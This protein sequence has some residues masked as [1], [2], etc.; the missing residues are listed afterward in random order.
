M[1]PA[2]VAQVQGRIARPLRVVL[3]RDR[4]AEQCH[5]AVAGELRDRPLESMHALGEELEEAVH[6]PMPL[7]GIEL[8]GEI[9]RAL[10]VGEQHGHL[11]P[12]TFEGAA[13]AENLLGEMRG[14]IGARIASDLVRDRGSKRVPALG[15]ELGHRADGVAAAR[16]T[17]GQR[18]PALLA[19]LGGYAVLVLAAGTPHARVWVSTPYPSSSSS[20]FASARSPV[21]KP[22]VNQA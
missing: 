14:S 3:V 9:H 11:L 22:S 4:R 15:A 21:S 18:R 16:A 8:L 5:D 19:E 7:L 20:A 12:L 17:D 10:H 2:Q 6:D 13:G 1:R